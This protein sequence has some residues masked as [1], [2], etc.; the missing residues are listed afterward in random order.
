M[1]QLLFSRTF[2]QARKSHVGTVLDQLVL[3]YV[4]P[5]HVRASVAACS[6]RVRA[7]RG[8]RFRMHA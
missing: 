1:K 7:C 4:A 2:V 5:L 6:M 8:I 3:V